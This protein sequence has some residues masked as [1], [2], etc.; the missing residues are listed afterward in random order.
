MSI[1]GYRRAEWPVAEPGPGAEQIGLAFDPRE[2]EGV[3][4][5]HGHLRAEWLPAERRPAGDRRGS[6]L[7][8]R[9]RVAA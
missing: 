3:M 7:V 1:H 4:N 5:T 2:C 8:V 9:E 6:A